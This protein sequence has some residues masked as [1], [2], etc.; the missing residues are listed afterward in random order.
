MSL[1]AFHILFVVVSVALTVGFGIWALS[2]D[3]GYTGWG[4][5]SFVAA[6]ALLVYG[7]TFLQKLK[8]ERL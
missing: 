5:A 1:K 2:E 6:A 8:K 4:I 7:V 3:R